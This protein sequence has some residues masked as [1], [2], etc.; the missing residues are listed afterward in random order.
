MI[1]MSFHDVLVHLL[2][3]FEL[4]RAKHAVVHIISP[5]YEMFER[6]PGRLVVR[7]ALTQEPTQAV[8]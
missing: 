5:G 1:A 8:Q 3:V 2:A 6:V 4:L 7:I